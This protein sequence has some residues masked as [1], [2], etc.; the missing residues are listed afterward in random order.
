LKKGKIVLAC[1]RAG[2]R[3]KKNLMAKIR[4]GVVKRERG[5]PLVWEKAE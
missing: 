2:E 4:E 1:V 3:G 5:E